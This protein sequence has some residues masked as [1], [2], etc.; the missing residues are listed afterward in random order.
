L[1]K[2]IYTIGFTKKTAESFFDILNKNKIDI[3][4]DIRL[5]NTS[6]LSGFAKSPDIKYFLKE[7]SNIDYIHDTELAPTKEILKNFKN[8]KITWN[9]YIDEFNLLMNSRKIDQYIIQTYNFIDKNICLL[10][11]ESEATECHR[12]LI[13]KYFQKNLDNIELIKN[14]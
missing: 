12:S 4:L 6:Q 3:I 11:S 10:C 14:L 8:K 5:N 7:I 9:E 1:V 2:Y 13:A